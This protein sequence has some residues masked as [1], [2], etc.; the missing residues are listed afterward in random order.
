MFRKR[1]GARWKKANNLNTGDNDAFY[2]GSGNLSDGHSRI[3]TGVT[4]VY[5]SPMPLEFGYNGETND[6]RASINATSM[7]EE[8]TVTLDN[9]HSCPLLG[10]TS[11][12]WNTLKISIASNRGDAG[13]GVVRLTHQHQI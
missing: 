13:D 12:M 6:L 10:V 3:K 11:D 8:L 1:T 7:N 2:V 4:Y 5:Q 9:F